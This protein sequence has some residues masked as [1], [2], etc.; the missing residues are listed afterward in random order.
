[1][2]N[3]IL[4]TIASC[5]ACSFLAAQDTLS[6]EDCRRLATENSPLQAQKA[7][8]AAIADLQRQGLRS[9]SLPRIAIG[10]Q[11]TFQSEVFGLPV[12]SPFFKVPTV[13]KDQYRASMDVAQRLWD[14]NTDRLRRQQ[15]ALE[16][17]LA[18]VQTDADAFSLRE[19]VTEL[20]FKILLL[21]ESEG[22]LEASRKDLD[23]RLKQAEAAV[24]AGAM[25]RS[26]ADQIRVQ[27][28][29]I[30]QQRAALTAD[31]QTLM[32]LLALWTGRENTAFFLKNQAAETPAE[33]A[34]RPEWGLF[35]L[36]SRQLDL[37]RQGVQLRR[38]PRIELFA[39]GGWGNPNPFNFF[40]SGLFGLVGLRAQWTPLDW[41]LSRRDK[42]IFDLQK[43]NIEAQK[44]A[45]EW[46]T[47]AWALKETREAEKQRSLLAQDD[48]IIA[49]QEQILA[50]ADAQLQNGVMTM[51][52]YL[53]QVSLLTQARIARKTHEIQIAQAREM[54]IA[55]GQ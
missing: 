48:S 32:E 11:V 31:K 54:Q 4:C 42:Q 22:V 53:A 2:K 15:F 1:M 7:Q 25:L 29:K 43:R 37:A 44:A 41:G 35:D 14:G 23:N 18:E 51:T 17:E 36:K 45:F 8:V 50:R 52:D 9:A 13:P 46:K 6:A 3:K 55:R 26:H 20:F 10:G 39:Q 28:L 40:E 5:L 24:E 33:V 49:L 30:E 38:Q 16:K 27:L 12:E 47:R 21:Q 19:T 34:E